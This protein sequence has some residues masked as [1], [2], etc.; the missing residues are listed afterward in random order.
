MEQL[1][2]ECPEITGE[3]TLIIPR[4][5]MGAMEAVAQ[6]IEKRLPRNARLHSN[7]H[8]EPGLAWLP[9]DDQRPLGRRLEP[10]ARQHGGL[11]VDEVED[12]V[13]RRE[14]ARTEEIPVAI[15]PGDGP[16]QALNEVLHK[17]AE[18]DITIGFNDD[19]QVINFSPADPEQIHLREEPP[20]PEEL[21]IDCICAGVR[22][23]TAPQNQ[24]E[25]F[26]E[27]DVEQRLF[28]HHAVVDEVRYN[29]PLLIA[30]AARAFACTMRVRCRRER[31]S[32]KHAI[33]IGVPV[34]TEI[35]ME[36]IEQAP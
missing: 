13:A 2:F 3:G 34:F 24:L 26:P 29:G 1:Q 30:W 4:S 10:V 19:E 21:T 20:E 35:P 31:P 9:I 14:A 27:Q 7:F 17:A 32:D 28:L 6:K 25:L 8:F 12:F 15:H 36:E 5:A 23:V 33:A 16:T 18:L 22:V 11:L